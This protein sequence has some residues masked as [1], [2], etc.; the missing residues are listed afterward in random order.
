MATVC[1]LEHPQF[2]MSTSKLRMMP[3]QK[4]SECSQR[5]GNRIGAPTSCDSPPCA[6]RQR[7]Q[8]P[9]CRLR[10]AKERHGLSR[11]SR[12]NRTKGSVL[13]ATAVKP[14]GKGSVLAATAVEPQG[15][16]SASPNLYIFLM[17]FA[18]MLSISTDPQSMLVCRFGIF[19]D[20]WPIA[21]WI[22]V[23]HACCSSVVPVRKSRSCT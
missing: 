6:P 2:A 18:S 14:Q 17:S 23:S 9:T 11:K 21:F 20:G 7:C 3:K 8:S 16:G 13:A 12:R 22:A 1:P 19:L 15:K 10:T 4:A 5:L